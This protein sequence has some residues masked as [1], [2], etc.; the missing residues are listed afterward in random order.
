MHMFVIKD[1]LTRP[2][3][4]HSYRPG[5][6]LH[7]GRM[8]Q[9]YYGPDVPLRYTFKEPGRYAVFV[10][11]MHGGNVITERFE[12]DV[13]GDPYSSAMVYGLYLAVGAFAFFVFKSDIKKLLGRKKTRRP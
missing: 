9:V 5:H 10:Q 13:Q 1:D 12:L 3:H 4:T 8:A 7:L 11:W 2:D 6:S